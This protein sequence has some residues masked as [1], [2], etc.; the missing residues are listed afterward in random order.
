MTKPSPNYHR[1]NVIGCIGNSTPLKG[2][3]LVFKVP[4]K[5]G[6]TWIVDEQILTVDFGRSAIAIAIAIAIADAS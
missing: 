1:A 6:F 3:T 4:H 2:I 5:C